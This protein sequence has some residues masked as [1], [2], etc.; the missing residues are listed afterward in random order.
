MVSM[1]W[2]EYTRSILFIWF[3]SLLLTVTGADDAKW[4]PEETVS[5][6]RRVEGAVPST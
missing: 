4:K 1:K 2:K 6:E 5:P 3:T